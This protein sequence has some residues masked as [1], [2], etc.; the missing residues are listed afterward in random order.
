MDASI[1]QAKTKGEDNGW[2]LF[3]KLFWSVVNVLGW[4]SLQ[5]IKWE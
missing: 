4:T 3:V 2:R 5:M 1:Q